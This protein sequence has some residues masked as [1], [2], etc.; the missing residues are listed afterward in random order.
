MLKT[1]RRLNPL[2]KDGWISLAA[3]VIFGACFFGFFG[4]A[5]GVVGAIGCAIAFFVIVRRYG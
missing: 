3:S 1:L 5:Q 2:T 4:V